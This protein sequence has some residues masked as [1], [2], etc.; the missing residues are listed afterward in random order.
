MPPTHGGGGSFGYVAPV[1]TRSQ[2]PLTNGFVSP[3]PRDG[4]SGQGQGQGGVVAPAGASHGRIEPS[5]PAYSQPS[6]RS[7]PA[8]APVQHYSPPPQQHYSPPAQHFSAPAPRMSSPAP[9]RSSGGF[10]HGSGGGG[11]HR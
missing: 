7:S 5:Q 10:S 2:M 11:R 6:Y 4:R 9:S 3:G 1:P 8:P